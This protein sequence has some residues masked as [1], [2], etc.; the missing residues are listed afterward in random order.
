MGLRLLEPKARKRD[1]EDMERARGFQSM[2][3]KAK[4]NSPDYPWVAQ[5]RRAQKFSSA[6]SCSCGSGTRR[7]PAPTM[8]PRKKQR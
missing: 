4:T 7:M 8:S 5:R 3:P 1:Y 6:M 2:A